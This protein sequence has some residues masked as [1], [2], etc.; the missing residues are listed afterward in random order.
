MIPGVRN[1][2]G[3]RV[4]ARRKEEG[5]KETPVNE[6]HRGCCSDASLV[7]TRFLRSSTEWPCKCA[8][9]EEGW[10]ASSPACI[11]HWVRPLEPARPFSLTSSPRRRV[12][13][14]LH[15]LQG[16]F[17]GQDYPPSDGLQPKGV[18]GRA[19]HL[20]NC[21]GSQVLHLKVTVS[22]LS[23]DGA[24]VP[25]TMSSR[26]QPLHKYFSMTN[27]LQDCCNSCD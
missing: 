15:S 14:C 2:E 25:R 20:L 23:W 26:L 6:H 24:Q 22:S 17:P 12:G 4:K 13:R 7:K 18:M 11:P 19:G 8:L 16:D 1:E 10:W 5:K 21:S 27:G 3:R 9:Q